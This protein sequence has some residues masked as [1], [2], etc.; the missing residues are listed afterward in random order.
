MKCQPLVLNKTSSYLVFLA[1]LACFPKLAP[2]VSSAC[3]TIGSDLRT[4]SSLTAT[5][6]A[7]S[8]LRRSAMK[9]KRYSDEQIV[10]AL[11]QVTAFGDRVSLFRTEQVVGA[12][13]D[14]GGS[15][16]GRV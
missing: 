13:Q 7:L 10:F 6:W 3:L 4:W 11:R 16:R 15:E 14:R 12:A 9:R 1:L 8:T 5:F 2:S